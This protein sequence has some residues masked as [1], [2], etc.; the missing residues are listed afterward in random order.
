MDR[1]HGMSVFVAVAEQGGFAAAA[2]QLR[3]SAPS[4][5]RAVAALEDRLGVRLLVRTTRRVRLTEPGARY[6]ADCRRL[7]AEID[8]AGAVAAGSH[9]APR[10]ELVIT[11]P[12]QFGRLHIVPTLPAFLARY[13]EVTLRGLLLDRVVDLVDEG[14]DVALRIAALPPSSLIARKVGAVRQVVVGSPSYLRDRPEPQH[15]RELVDHVLVAASS[16][17]T[18]EAWPFEEG[19]RMVGQ[20]VRSRLSLSTPDAA[21]DAVRAG[22]GLTRVPSYQVADDLEAGRLVAVLE[23]FAPPPV[24]VSLVRHGDRRASAKVRAFVDFMIDRLESSPALR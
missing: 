8:E 12:T 2:R 14:V 24:P 19:G 16:L 11:A 5:T 1:I 4:V 23:R 10:G 9:G 21:L 13:P 6:L 7:L 3:L 22:F 17:M 20:K 18:G 15:P